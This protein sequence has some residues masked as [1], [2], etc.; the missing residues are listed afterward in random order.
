[1]LIDKFLKVRELRRLDDISVLY[2]LCSLCC[3]NSDLSVTFVIEHEEHGLLISADVS[4]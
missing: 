2:S 4:V 3:H 1:M